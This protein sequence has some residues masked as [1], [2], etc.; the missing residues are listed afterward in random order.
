MSGKK[1]KKIPVDMLLAEPKHLS[2]SPALDKKNKRFQWSRKAA[3]TRATKREYN[4][5][6]TVKYVLDKRTNTMKPTQEFIKLKRT[7]HN[8]TNK[9]WYPPTGDNATAKQLLKNKQTKNGREVRFLG[10]I[11]LQEFIDTFPNVFTNPSDEDIKADDQMLNIQLAAIPSDL[12]KSLR[13]YQVFPP[14][15]SDAEALE[16]IDRFSFYPDVLEKTDSDGGVNPNFDKVRYQEFKNQEKVS[17]TKHKQALMESMVSEAEVDIFITMA[18]YITKGSNVEVLDV[19]GAVVCLVGQKPSKTITNVLA[20]KLDAK[21]PEDITRLFSSKST[22]NID[23][24]GLAPDR[25]GGITLK[26]KSDDADSGNT[27]SGTRR[28]FKLKFTYTDMEGSVHTARPN[29]IWSGNKLSVKTV[30]EEMKVAVRTKPSGETT[31]IFNF[32]EQEAEV[33]LAAFEAAILQIPKKGEGKKEYVRP[34][35]EKNIF[36][37]KKSKPVDLEDQEVSEEDQED[38][39]M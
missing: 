29:M 31:R 15:I 9:V 5:V 34:V 37:N 32:N 11:P 20:D 38:E 22:K 30:I 13:L 27:K 7:L 35:K 26:K 36:S 2:G 33:Q 10:A 17:E 8:A 4:S 6:G 3:N 24:N 25:I 21:T 23:I 39:E 14:S 28:N 18:G 16:F 12:L 1:I 19:N